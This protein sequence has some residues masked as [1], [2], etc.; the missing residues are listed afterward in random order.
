[1]ELQGKVAIV[2]GGGSG[3]GRGV[4]LLLASEGARVIVAD[5]DTLAA[6]DTVSQIGQAGGEAAAIQ[7]DVSKAHEVGT[8]VEQT[9]G[10]WGRIDILVNNAGVSSECAFLE[11]EESEWDWVLA[12]NLKGA[13]LCGQAVA[14]TMV[15][16]GRGGKI[17]NITSVNSEVVGQG[18]CHYCASKG[19]LRMLT[20]AM[21]AELARYK[22]NVNAV[23]PG[24]V[25]TALTASS[26][27]D[28]GKLQSLLGHV[29]WGRV[30]EPSDVAEAVL[31]LASG[32][33]DYVTGV[34]LFV[35]GGWLLE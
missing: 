27:A 5:V 17:V 16:T 24:I 25:R 35:D 20:K 8:L 1:M 22:I 14:R 31:F 33:A 19:G 13:F 10:R 9:L 29:P 30:G 32:R 6:E 4:S 23:A 26:L 21:A 34:S 18:L 3:I 11:I 12:V 7:T 15:Q 2:T 28:R